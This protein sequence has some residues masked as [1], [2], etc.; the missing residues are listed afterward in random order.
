MMTI[1]EHFLY[2][3]FILDAEAQKLKV[4]GRLATKKTP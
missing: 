1:L 2:R 3:A 4:P